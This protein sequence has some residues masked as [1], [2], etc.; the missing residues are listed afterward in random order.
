[1]MYISTRFLQPSIDKLAEKVKQHAGTPL[2]ETLDNAHM[3]LLTLINDAIIE[4]R[5]HM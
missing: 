3:E 2:W 5:I 4:S 1:M